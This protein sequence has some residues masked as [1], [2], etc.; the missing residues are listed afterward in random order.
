MNKG[1][2]TV[3]FWRIFVLF[4][5]VTLFGIIS[6]GESFASIEMDRARDLGKEIGSTEL[7]S[8][9]GT[10]PK[11]DTTGYPGDKEI[12][13]PNKA[14]S[15]VLSE[16]IPETEATKLLKDPKVQNN[17][18][19]IDQNDPAFLISKSVFANPESKSGVITAS[20][21]SLVNTNT[22]TH[23]CQESGDPYLLST[24]RT[25][26][27]EVKYTPEKRI[28]VK[29]C[30]GHSESRKTY[31]KG[32]ADSA[33]SGRRSDLQ[34]DKDIRSYSVERSSGNWG[35]MDDYTISTK[36]T[37]IDDYKWCNS[38]YEE[39]RL[40]AREKW[41][42]LSDT[43]VLS[44]PAAGQ[45]MLGPDCYLSR[46]S[47]LEKNLTKKIQDRVSGKF[48]E[49]FRGCWKESLVFVCKYP[50]VKGCDVLR[51]K[52]C[53]EVSSRC[54]KSGEN[55]CA[56]WEKTYNCSSSKRVLN[57]SCNVSS[58]YG[59]DGKGFEAEYEENTKFPEI[60]AKLSI[61]DSMRGELRK[62]GASDARNVKVFAGKPSKCTKN[63]AENLMYDCCGSFEG[64]MNRIGLSYCNAEEQQLAKDKKDSKCHYIGNHGREILQGLW[65]SSYEHVYCCFPSKFTRVLQEEARKQLGKSWGSSRS[66]DC[67]GL[68]TN[69]ISRL[70]F[71]KM[72]L[73]E[74]LEDFKKSGEEAAKEK[75]KNFKD[76]LPKADALKKK[77]D[78]NM[79]SRGV[80]K[81]GEGV[82]LK[83]KARNNIG[84]AE[85]F[86]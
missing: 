3:K 20:G 56:L 29:I 73:S 49:V 24:T 31:W 51:G 57:S 70:N 44:N 39:D 83:D 37:H 86:K 32:D 82:D 42:E 85:R 47:C 23:K 14:Q 21:S 16:D 80:F 11:V 18:Y 81:D 50:P 6:L 53:F 26:N 69:E 13:D 8:M 27:A 2:L 30:R 68:T 77:V 79:E 78:S 60:A 72:D 43:F 84:S 66:P 58:I 48:K 64:L 15:Q 63:I 10:L 1:Y 55:G 46:S 61:F 35:L 19:K 9:G 76:N 40:V 25:R 12:F 4:Q 33:V 5:I 34:K 28:K 7:N 54:I 62:S 38:S 45:E 41:E 36:Y 22:G 59:A 71:E 67:L 52:G 74:I 65:V 17:K 75:I